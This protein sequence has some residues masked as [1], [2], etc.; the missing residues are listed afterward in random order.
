ML[1]LQLTLEHNLLFQILNGKAITLERLQ[2]KYIDGI[3]SKKE[4]HNFSLLKKSRMTYFKGAYSN[5]IFCFE[6][7]IGDPFFVILIVIF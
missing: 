7:F 5:S 6:D 2:T 3:A 1:K 4:N